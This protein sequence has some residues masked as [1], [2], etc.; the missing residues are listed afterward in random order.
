MQPYWGFG[1]ENKPFGNKTK[2]HL[3]DGQRRR[4]PGL[5]QRGLGHGQHRFH[6]S[7]GE[8]IGLV[9]ITDFGQNFILTVKL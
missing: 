2:F 4:P 5:L 6:R 3:L 8:K 1:F 7:G 9:I